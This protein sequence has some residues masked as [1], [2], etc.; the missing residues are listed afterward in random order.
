MLLLRKRFD[1]SLTFSASLI[2]GCVVNLVPRIIAPTENGWPGPRFNRQLNTG[3]EEIIVTAENAKPLRIS[4]TIL[5][6]QDKRHGK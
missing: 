4:I 2:V 1:S 5:N 6:D 3:A